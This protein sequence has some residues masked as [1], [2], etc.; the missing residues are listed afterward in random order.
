MPTIQGLDQ[1]VSPLFAAHIQAVRLFM[2]DFAQF[3]LMTDGEEN[4]DRMIAWATLDFLSDFNGTPPFT[5]MRLQD[6]Y[7]RQLQALAV[8]GTV[9]TLLQSI[10]LLMIRNYLPFSDGGISVPMNDKAPLIA[11]TLQL[12]Q[13]AYE[14]NKRMVK[15]AMNVELLM[16]TGPSG[17]L[18][19]Y[20]SLQSYGYF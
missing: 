8:R 6:V 16:D 12:L 4:S 15:T 1:D 3:N 5:M 2:R 10:N 13:S 14:Q 20:S 17:V 7:N 18:S 9:I 19:D 11:S